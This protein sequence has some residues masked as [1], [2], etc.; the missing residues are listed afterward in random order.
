MKRQH[1]RKVDLEERVAIDDDELVLQTAQRLE[2]RARGA[3]R[4]AIVHQAEVEFPV[5][6]LRAET[7]DLP[8]LVVDQDHDRARRPPSG[9]ARSGARGVACPG[10]RRAV[11]AGRSGGSPG[12]CPCRPPG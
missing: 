6:A 7:L 1:P 4:L 5:R 8:G 10:R 9:V 12:A 11:S 3:G 2:N